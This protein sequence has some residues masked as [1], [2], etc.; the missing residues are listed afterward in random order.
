[1]A[2]DGAG[3]SAKVGQD[4]FAGFAVW[5]R[6]SSFRID[7]PGEKFIVKQ[8][9]ASEVRGAFAGDGTGLGETAAVEAFGC[10]GFL[11]R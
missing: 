10:P 11:Q 1:M 7:A 5:G 4:P 2:D 3:E 9:Q 8:V 6:F